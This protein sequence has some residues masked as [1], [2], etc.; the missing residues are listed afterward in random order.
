[1]EAVAAAPVREPM[2]ML[3]PRYDPDAV[4]A[5]VPRLELLKILPMV[6]RVLRAVWP[7]PAG[8]GWALATRYED[9]SEV[10]QRH[11]AFAVP[12]DEEIGFL[13][14]GESPGTPFLL[15]IDDVAA[16]AAQARLVMQ[17]FRRGDIDSRVAPAA[18][19][20]A[21]ATI[22]R[23]PGQF[24]AIQALVTGVP[25][26]V[27]RTYYGIALPDDPRP[28]ACASM[29]LSGHLFGPPPVNGAASRQVLAAGAYVRAVVDAAIEGGK[30]RTPALP[31]TVL[32]RLLDTNARHPDELTLR[33][34]RAILIGM[35][36]GFVPTNT[37]AGGHILQ[38]LLDHPDRLDRARAAALA[39][40]DDLLWRCLFEALRFMPH[41]PGPFRICRREHVLAADTLRAK[42]I[43]PGT[44]VL[45][46]TMSAMFD[47]R[48]VRD[49]RRF[50]PARPASDY[51]LFGYGM[52]WCVGAAIAQAQL[53]QT[54]KALLAA[55][56][57][58]RAAGADG[59]L[60]RRGGFPERLCITLAR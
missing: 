53:T 28:F 27:C 56:R 50:D 2:Q 20:A 16:H 4:R 24:D 49:P 45:A 55:G 30:L 57:P 12:F 48:Q 18:F 36:V 35:V 54:F 9:V 26:D 17:A 1:M 47:A 59:R 11:D 43:K 7:I 15:G 39:G 32:S 23:Q 29:D 41:N 60:R 10:L 22:A 3:L 14:D 40:D 44:K 51:M 46:A 34:V 31:G 42:R 58:R 37:L 6:F 38:V 8:F 25:L 52:H 33:Q 5:R 21:A 19:A 13:N